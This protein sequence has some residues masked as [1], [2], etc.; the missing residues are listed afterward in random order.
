MDKEAKDILEPLL[1]VF[2]ELMNKENKKLE[3]EWVVKIQVITSGH[4]DLQLITEAIEEAG[5]T[6]IIEAKADFEPKEY[7]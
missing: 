2:K 7:H 3:K 5:F 1:D 4:K 6:N